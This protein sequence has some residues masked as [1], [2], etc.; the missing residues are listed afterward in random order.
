M[1]SKRN[2]STQ[3][4]LNKEQREYIEDALKQNMTMK[5]IKLHR[6]EKLPNTFNN[7]YFLQSSMHLCFVIQ[8]SKKKHESK[9]IFKLCF[10]PFFKKQVSLF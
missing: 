4:Y 8:Y 1:K 9:S 10:V 6:I 2:K 7:E 3:K 5:E